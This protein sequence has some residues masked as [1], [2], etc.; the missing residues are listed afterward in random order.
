M[1]RRTLLAASALPLAAAAQGAWQPRGP[2]TVMYRPPRKA[3]LA[4]VMENARRFAPAGVFVR[5]NAVGAAGRQRG[6]S[7]RPIRRRSIERA[8]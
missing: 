8:A 3:F 5:S 7:V 4:P 1:K 6:R 2:I